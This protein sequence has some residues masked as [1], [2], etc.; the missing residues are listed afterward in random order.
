[1]VGCKMCVRSLLEPIMFFLVALIIIRQTVVSP[2]DLLLARPS[3]AVC[4][5][6]ISS[7]SNVI[8]N[9][10]VSFEVCFLATLNAFGFVFPNFGNC[11]FV[12]HSF[13][14]PFFVFRC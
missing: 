4:R 13:R 11:A 7:F 3:R 6:T 14:T 1:M 5:D 2:V 9:Q 8:C 10:V 12:F